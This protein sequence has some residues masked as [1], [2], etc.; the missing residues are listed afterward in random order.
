MKDRFTLSVFSHLME[1]TVHQKD[2]VGLTEETVLDVF[3]RAN[4]VPPAAFSALTHKT[5]KSA[6][7]SL[8]VR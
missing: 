3:R 5:F 1:I 7:Q 8:G 2:K 4:P 6:A